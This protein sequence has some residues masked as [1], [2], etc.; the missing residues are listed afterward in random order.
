ML[1]YRDPQLLRTLQVYRDAS[2]WAAAGS[3]S[4][5]DIREAILAVFG[6]LDRPV[7]PAGKGQREFG[8]RLQ[9]LSAD[10][11][12]ALREGI[13]AVD[14]STLMRLTDTYLLAGWPASA[15]GVVSSEGLLQEANLELGE[16]GLK[17]EK[18]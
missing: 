5:E 13:L 10:S 14:R 15:V 17:L 1:S 4:D 9:G 2:A 18:I 8:Y 7:S 6:N 11:R 12:Q 16:K 3:F